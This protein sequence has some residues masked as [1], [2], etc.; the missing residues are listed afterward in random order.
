M[1]LTFTA[2]DTSQNIGHLA[3]CLRQSGIRAVGRYYTKNR[4]HA[5]I[6]TRLEADALASAGIRVW[7]TYQNRQDRAA[8]FTREK[9]LAAASDAI[10]YA[11]NVIHQPLG[12]GIYFSVDFDA[13]PKHYQQNILPYFNAVSEVFASKQ[14]PYRI[15]VY[16]SG[17]VCKD[18]LAAKLVSLTWLSQSTGFRGT[19]I[20]KSSNQW[21][22]FQR[23]GVSQFCDL[24]DRPDPDD[25]NAALGDFGAFST[26]VMQ[27]ATHVLADAATQPMQPGADAASPQGDASTFPGLPSYPGSPVHRGE[28]ASRNVKLV[29]TRLNELRYGPLVV[30][31]DFGEATQNATFHFQARNC[32]AGGAPLEIS[33]DIDQATWGALFG[34]GS[35]FSTANLDE[36]LPLRQLVI[37]IAATQIGVREQPVGSNRGP[38]VDQYI[39]SVGLDPTADSYPWCVCFLHWVFGEATKLKKL[40]NPLPGTA[41]VHVLWDKGKVQADAVVRLGQASSS[42]VKPGMIFTIDTGGGH[43]H[44]GLVIDV[45][46]NSIVT[47]EGNTNTGGSP[48]GFGVFRRDQRPI[49]MARLLGYLDFCDS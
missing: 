28:T 9:G 33:G 46:S 39:R 29:Q 27:P 24:K 7:V 32:G 22:I 26:S 15:G 13:T 43:G 3:G 41:G 2:L 35:L 25:I 36:S 5:K 11:Q 18:L 44:A 49:D 38:E 45:K 14:N 42:T 16:G 12:T 8:D 37:D 19:A 40:T 20:F 10:E 17:A 6:L 4:G 30:D 48:E 34:A 31:G 21:N 47:I 23:L 1:S